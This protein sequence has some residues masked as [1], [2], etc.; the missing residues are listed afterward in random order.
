MPL[1]ALEQIVLLSFAVRE[2]VASCVCVGAVSSQMRS[3]RVRERNGLP[4]GGRTR[5]SKK[6]ERKYT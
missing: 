2:S 1:F 4:G 3:E 5:K 6:E